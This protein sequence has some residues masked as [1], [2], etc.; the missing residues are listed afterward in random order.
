MFKASLLLLSIAL[1]ISLG[2]P[3]ASA[4]SLDENRMIRAAICELEGSK[5]T[6][7]DKSKR[8]LQSGQS[9]VA[10]EKT[11][12]DSYNLPTSIEVI[13]QGANQTFQLPTFWT[14]KGIPFSSCQD[15]TA[16]NVFNFGEMIREFY[17]KAYF[18]AGEPRP[19]DNIDDMVKNG[20][21]IPVKIRILC[22]SDELSDDISVCKEITLMDDIIPL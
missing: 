20:Q 15:L 13:Y 7:F 2:L 14:R 22:K 17:V 11:P 10:I 5:Y 1:E 16:W 3:V 4:Q 18:I 9:Y 19:I 21:A 12:H 8:P 6:I